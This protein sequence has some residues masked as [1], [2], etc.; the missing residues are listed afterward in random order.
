DPDLSTFE[1]YMLV[2]FH[3]T[4]SFECLPHQALHIS[5]SAQ[6]QMLPKHPLSLLQQVC[7]KVGFD[8]RKHMDNVSKSLTAPFKGYAQPNHKQNMVIGPCFHLSIIKGSF[9]ALKWNMSFFQSANCL[10]WLK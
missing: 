8:L 4:S 2:P 5:L 10:K 7:V 6:L 3:Q 9:N 1:A